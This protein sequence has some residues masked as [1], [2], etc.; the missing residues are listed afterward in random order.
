MDSLP[1][2]PS[3]ERGEI[4]FSNNNRAVFVKASLEQATA[5]LLKTLE[6]KKPATVLLVIGGADDLDAALNDQIEYLLEH[7]LVLAA[8][9]TNALIIDGG[10][11]AGVM[12]LMGKVIALRGRVAPLLGI[13]PEGKV[14]Y[15]GGPTAG[16]IA[17]GAELDPNH[18]H[19]ILVQGAEWSGGTDL[20][21]KLV[22]ELAKEARV[23]VVLMNG[24][25]QTRDEVKRAAKLGWPVVVIQGSGRL[26]DE[27]AAELTFANEGNFQVFSLEGKPGELRQSLIKHT[28]GALIDAWRRL[29]QYDSTATANQRRHR[30]LLSFTLAIGV[31]GT[32]FALSQKQFTGREDETFILTAISLFVAVP[33]LLMGGVSVLKIFRPKKTQTL[34]TWWGIAVVAAAVLLLL[35]RTLGARTLLTYAAFGFRYLAIAVP[36]IVS[37]LLTASNQ[38]KNRRKWILLRDSAE[39]IK[40]EIFRYR[41]RVGDYAEGDRWET[42]PNETPPVSHISRDAVLAQKIVGISGRLMRTEVNTGSL[43]YDGPLPPEGAVAKTDDGFSFLTPERYLEVRL[44]DQLKYYSGTTA[45][46]E[47]QRS[48]LQWL[49]FIVGGAG[50]LL[51]ALGAQLW[52]ALTTA[53][54][55]ALSAWVG[56]LKLDQTLIKYNQSAADLSDLRVLWNTLSAEDKAQLNSRQNLVNKTEEILEKERSVWA[57]QMEETKE[58]DKKA[59]KGKESEEKSEQTPT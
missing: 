59:A 18:S 32:L 51:A 3:L 23:V 12:E 35:A 53:A 22:A 20:M 44:E 45:K 25:D 30:W 34:L 29:G 43:L 14:T 55:T 15:P 47:R 16:S 39:A 31:L 7:G 1:N 37:I 6:I 24:G 52:I 11:K 4:R 8:A 42:L 2:N 28:E 5:D 54:V 49:I 40:T 36:V 58:E 57:Q 46:L 19:F 56:D 17:G 27:I 38:F 10:T 9:D 13:A 33:I 26:A 41:M 50:T 48:E 21:F